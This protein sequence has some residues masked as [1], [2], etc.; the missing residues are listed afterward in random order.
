MTRTPFHVLID[1]VYVACEATI[2]HNAQIKSLHLCQIQKGFCAVHRTPRVRDAIKVVN[3]LLDNGIEWDG[4]V[5]VARGNDVT[6]W[7]VLAA[8][9]QRL[10]IADALPKPTRF[11]A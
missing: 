6:T 1:G 11:R 2:D 3:A 5:S 8:E 9:E 7:L 10:A 4:L